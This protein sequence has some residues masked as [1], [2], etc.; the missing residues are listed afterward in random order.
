LLANNP[1]ANVKAELAPRIKA[2]DALVRELRNI[3]THHRPEDQRGE[4][5]PHGAPA[6]RGLASAANVPVAAP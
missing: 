6:S 5:M 4:Q 2:L 3:V 1:D